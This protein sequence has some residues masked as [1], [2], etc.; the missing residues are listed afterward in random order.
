MAAGVLAYRVARAQGLAE[1]N[2]RTALLLARWLLDN[3]GVDGGQILP[4]DDRVIADL[5]VRAAS[6][7]VVEEE[8]TSILDPRGARLTHATEIDWDAA[9]NQDV[10]WRLGLCRL[11]GIQ[12]N[13][14]ITSIG[15]QTPPED[16][17][18]CKNL[19]GGLSGRSVFSRPISLQLGIKGVVERTQHLYARQRNRRIAGQLIHGRGPFTPWAGPPGSARTTHAPHRRGG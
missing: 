4:H 3:D 14:V 15:C 2:K 17:R 13:I 1:G 5:L 6:G 19:D 18:N 8:I 9:K 16:Q 11:W 12:A 7:T 10:R